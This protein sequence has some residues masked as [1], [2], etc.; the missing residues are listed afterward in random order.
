MTTN[1]PRILVVDDEPDIRRL[2]CEILEDEGYQ[3][4]SAE[5][6]NTARALKT[7]MQPNLILLDIWMPDT[8]GITLLKEWVT[9]D[10]LL[11]PVI[12]MSG[13]GSVEAAVEATRLG[14]YDF[15]E[16]PFSMDQ[17]VSH[18]RYYLHLSSLD[19]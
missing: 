11:C 10:T 2:V 1:T 13:H 6:A 3:V 5:D 9:E 12:M 17:L 7:S 8:D 4:S 15:L 18:I 19:H 16:K 14:A